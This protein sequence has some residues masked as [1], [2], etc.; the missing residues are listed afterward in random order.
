MST[1]RGPIGDCLFAN[2]R[3]INK[4]QGE[5]A[6][7]VGV[8]QSTISDWETG[9]TSFSLDLI[10]KVARSYKLEED[11]LKLLSSQGRGRNSRK[12]HQDYGDVL[13]LIKLVAQSELLNLSMEELVFL[14]T[15]EEHLGSS[16][17]ETQIE[18][19][20]RRK[21]EGLITP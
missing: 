7:E 20:L 5:I 19:V 21:R 16:L 8:N 4:S 6:K 13:P 17:T 15:T 3:R 10:E 18:S 12:Y 14:L 1:D 11:H 9:K 2:R